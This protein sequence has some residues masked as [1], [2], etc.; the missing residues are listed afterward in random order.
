MASRRPTATGPGTAL[1][2][3]L[4]PT[5]RHISVRKRLYVWMRA[6]LRWVTMLMLAGARWRTKA[7]TDQATRWERARLT[8]D[9]RRARGSANCMQVAGMLLENL[10]DDAIA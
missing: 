3:A 6:A 2:T 7:G 5:T 1:L 9:S 8:R 4:M 10:T